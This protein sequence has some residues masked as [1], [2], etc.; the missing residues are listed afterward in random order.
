MGCLQKYIN[1]PFKVTLRRHLYSPS[2]GTTRNIDG[3]DED[4]SGHNTPGDSQTPIL[5][6]VEQVTSGDF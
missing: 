4:S 1:H 6:N 5:S 2:V 3:D